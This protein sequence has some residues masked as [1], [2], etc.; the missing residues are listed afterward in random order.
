MRTQNEI[1]KINFTTINFP[2]D[3]ITVKMLRQAWPDATDVEL[4]EIGTVGERGYRR[5]AIDDVLGCAIIDAERHLAELAF[6]TKF[7][8]SR[9]S[10]PV[11]NKDDIVE[12]LGKEYERF[13][14]ARGK[15]EIATMIRRI[16]SQAEAQASQLGAPPRR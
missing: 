10:M 5:R 3:N 7:G 11:F 8:Q 16:E 15:H 12:A 2:S 4:G 9:K 1:H 13:G 6:R 14:L